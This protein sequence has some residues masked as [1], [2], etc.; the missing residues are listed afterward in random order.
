M[1]P[2]GTV[3][4]CAGIIFLCKW[5]FNF[6]WDIK[7]GISAFVIPR[8]FSIN[9]VEKYGEWAVI[10][11][12]TQGIG[13]C[14][15]EELARKRMNIVLISRNQSKLKKFATELNAKYGRL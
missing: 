15:A 13:K 6:L 5:V 7:D 12:C 10:T 14:Y 4:F 8:I 1:I 11:G 9:Y 2:I 3:V